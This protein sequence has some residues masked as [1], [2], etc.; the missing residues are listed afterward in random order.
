M[1]KTDSE[2]NR[3]WQSG[4]CRSPLCRPG[5][6]DV[7][8][9]HVGQVTG[10]R[11]SPLDRQLPREKKKKKSEFDVTQLKKKNKK[12]IHRDHVMGRIMALQKTS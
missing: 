8:K 4:L 2:N 11:S 9:K 3:P 12:E 5:G 10:K 1:E 7:Q 6:Q